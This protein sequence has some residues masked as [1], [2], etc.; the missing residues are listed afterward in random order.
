MRKI[1]KE[2]EFLLYLIIKKTAY[3][4]LNKTKI[5]LNCRIG[6]YNKIH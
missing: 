4:I 2:D 1:N 6:I 3:K 5:E